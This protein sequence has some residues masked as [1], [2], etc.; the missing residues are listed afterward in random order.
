MAVS[1]LGEIITKCSRLTEDQR[2]VE[3]DLSEVEGMRYSRPIL[4]D[5]RRDDA[6]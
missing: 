1:P 3:L 4:G 5:A 6:E 2:A